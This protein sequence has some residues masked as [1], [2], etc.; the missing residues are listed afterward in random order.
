MAKSSR[1]TLII[2]RR[3]TSMDTTAVSC[4]YNC[5]VVLVQLWLGVGTTVVSCWFNC[6]VMLVQLRCRI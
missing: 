6:G 5:G 1:Q 4:W 3:L 2:A